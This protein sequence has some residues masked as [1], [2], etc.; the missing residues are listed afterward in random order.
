MFNIFRSSSENV[1]YKTNVLS[2][3][4]SNCAGKRK[5]LFVL[6]LQ[7]LITTMEDDDKIV[8]KPVD[9]M[10]KLTRKFSADGMIKVNYS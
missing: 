1:M 7:K 6:F 5:Y 2:Y 4:I 9:G 10:S 3:L 8:T